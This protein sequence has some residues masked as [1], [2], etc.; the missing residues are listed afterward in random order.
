[1]R[2]YPPLEGAVQAHV[3]GGRGGGLSALNSAMRGETV[4]PHRLD[5]RTLMEPTA[6]SRDG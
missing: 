1:M 4:T 3:S 6:P 2:T 5:P